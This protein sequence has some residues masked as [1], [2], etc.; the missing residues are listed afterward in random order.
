MVARAGNSARPDDHGPEPV[1]TRQSAGLSI[2]RKDNMEKPWCGSTFSRKHRTSAQNLSKI[3]Y[4]GSGKTG[5]IFAQIT[6]LEATRII[7]S[8]HQEGGA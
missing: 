6:R 2:K 8:R 7:Q 3:R 4:E 1:A 5:N